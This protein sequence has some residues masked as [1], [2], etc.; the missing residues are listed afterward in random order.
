M[1]LTSCFVEGLEPWGML[2][3]VLLNASKEDNLNQYKS[4]IDFY[5]KASKELEDFLE[6]YTY[7][8]ENLEKWFRR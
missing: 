3:G 7:S 2:S 5:N 1:K 8:V 4:S 6:I